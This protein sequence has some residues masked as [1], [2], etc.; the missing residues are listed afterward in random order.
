M[1]MFDEEVNEQEHCCI[2]TIDS[3]YCA[4]LTEVKLDTDLSL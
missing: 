4:T 3:H 2:T 1:R